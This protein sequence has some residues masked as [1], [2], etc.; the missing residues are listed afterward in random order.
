M[1]ALKRYKRR[2]KKGRRYNRKVPLY[3][4]VGGK[5]PGSFPLGKSFK[6]TMRY[7]EINFN[8]NPGALGAPD[9]YVFSLNGLYDPNITSGGHQPLG[10]DQLM[11]MY[12]HYTV[13]GARARITFANQDTIRYALGIV[14]VKDTPTT[15]STYSELQNVV[16][17]GMSKY[18]TLGPT[19]NSSGKCDMT[20]N[21]SAKQFFGKSVVTEHDF[22]GTASANPTEQAYLHCIIAPTQP[23]VDNQETRCT[24][25]LEYITIFHEPKQLVSS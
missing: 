3:R 7:A 19:D 22:R 23:T 6:T 17:N 20:I 1:P 13:I 4:M 11:T 15:I 14:Q 18:C 12:N 10:F 25:L 16:E 8:L 24:V 9:S 2:T 21:W 5:M